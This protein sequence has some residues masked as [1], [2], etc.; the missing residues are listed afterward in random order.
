MERV[1]RIGLIS[2]LFL[3][4]LAFGGTEPIC[5]SAVQLLL[6]GLGL[7]FLLGYGSL[8]RPQGR[9]PLAVPLLLVA[10]VLLQLLPSFFFLG[11]TAQPGPDRPMLSSIAPY[12]T[13]SHFLLLLTYLSAFYLTLV[14]APSRRG[15]RQLVYGLLTLGT[16]VA[17]YGLVQHLTGWRPLFP[18]GDLFPLQGATGTYVN[19]NHFAGFLEMIIPFSLALVLTGFSQLRHTQSLHGREPSEGAAKVVFWLFLAVLFFAALVFS[20]SRMGLISSLISVLIVMVVFAT[21]TRRRRSETVVA[22]LVFLA[23]GVLMAVW[24]GPDPVLARFELLET[25]AAG[26][27]GRWGIWQDALQLIRQH[28]WLG[29]GLGTFPVAYPAVQTV[30]LNG[31][32]NHAHNDY[33]EVAS[34]IGILGAVIL[35]GA[36][37]YT[38]VAVIRR[39]GRHHDAVSQATGIGAIGAMAAILCH[40]LTDFNLYIPANALLFSVVLGLGYRASQV[41]V[42]SRPPAS[43]HG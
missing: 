19:R 8:P 6:F 38:F 25:Q 30:H 36:I 26:V 43:L 28:P 31:F 4:V 34:E 23:A 32:V 9:L 35:F 20:R 1:G 42:E 5:F 33:L 13:L 41:E 21:L 22:A 24:I 2:A 14:V 18:G 10:L 11:R 17:V 27:G 12:E 29:T 37:L 15:K 39:V 16:I 7:L 3:A 40:S